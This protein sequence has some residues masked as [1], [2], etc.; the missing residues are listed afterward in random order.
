MQNLFLLTLIYFNSIIASIETLIVKF[1]II[2]QWN[3]MESHKK[4]LG[5]NGF[6][7]FEKVFNPIDLEQI[8]KTSLKAVET[9]TPDQRKNFK[10]QG[11]LIQLADYPEFSDLI[12]H[13]KLMNIFMKLGF[14][15]TRFSSGY[16]I[17]KPPKA[18]ALFWHQDWWGWEHPI[19]YTDQVAQLFVMIYLQDTTK[20]N[21]C[22][23]VVPGS[24]R[25]PHFLHD[26][27]KAHTESVSR[28]EDSQDTLYLSV[29]EEKPVTVQFG[30]VVVGDARLLHGA[31]PNQSYDERT[32]ITLWFHPNYESLPESVQVRIREI[33]IRKEVDTDPDGANSMSLYDWP[34]K[35]R[36]L[37]EPL[38]PLCP[39][40]VEPEAWNRRPKWT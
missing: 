4:Q 16:I 30:D 18:P 3:A 32:L 23:R 5:K 38:F 10:S 40:D 33:F 13:Q 27:D 21:G 7:V 39:E 20:N 22:L 19:S 29:D 11:S 34:Q 6:C 15:D 2:F 8:V 36:D 12:C 25:N 9:L 14:S 24:H 28:V 26:N 35:N 17:S 1:C 37:V 31:F